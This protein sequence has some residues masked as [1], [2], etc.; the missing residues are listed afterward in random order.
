MRGC[1]NVAELHKDPAASVMDSIC[2]AF[3]AF[4]RF[5]LNKPGTCTAPMASPLGQV[6]S[7]MISPADARWR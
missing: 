6:P 4:D 1:A 3:P 2:H 5:S 7:V